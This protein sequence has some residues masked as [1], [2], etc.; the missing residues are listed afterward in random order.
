[1]DDCCGNLLFDAILLDAPCS[2]SG[3]IRRNPDIRLLLKSGHL[4]SHQEVQ[5]KLLHNLWRRLKE[6]GT[7]LY[8][9]CSIFEEENDHVIEKFISTQADAKSVALS[10]KHGRTTLLGW[11]LLPSSRSTDGFYY[12]GLT[13][14]KGT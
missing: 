7:L 11:Q 13:K 1:M 6:G 14:V 12:A 2:G 3:T 4:T 10:M 9:T 8:S 5:L